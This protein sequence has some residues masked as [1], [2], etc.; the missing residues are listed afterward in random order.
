[1]IDTRL[2]RR[3]AV[4][5]VFFLNGLTLSTYIVR[6]PSFKSTHALSDALFGLSGLLFALAA[7]VCM[8]AVGPLAARIGTRTILAC[9]LA[10][11]PLLLA[12]LAVA[13]GP[14]WYLAGA[15]VLGGVHG[16]T[17]AAMNASAVAVERA[18]GR[19]I[20]NGCHAAWSISAVIAS[21]ST[22]A[23]AHAGVSLTVHLITAAAVLLLAGMITARRL[24]DSGRSETSAP[25]RAGWSRPLVLLG[26]TATALMICEGA[27]L[28][29][30]GIFLHEERGASLSLAA[31]GITAYTGAQALGRLAGDRFTDR[32]RLFRVGAAIA[33]CG[34]TIGVL[35]PHPGVA[36]AGFA[37][38]GLGSS[39]LVPLT[40]SAVGRLPGASA[41]ALVS[42]LT[43]F[44]YSGILLGPALIGGVAD[45][46]G[47]APT[48][49]VVIPLML[50]ALLLFPTQRGGRP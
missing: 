48:M 37:L 49:T 13:P 27:A 18:A 8:Q 17:D 12:G 16:A 46:I 40:F 24:P 44:T 4:T 42:R 50:L 39:V 35:A 6:A 25:A 9:A 3:W 2:D 34:F 14:R 11:M 41:A 33:T 38:A 19:P 43:T 1:M 21:L 47:L 23:L 29:W 45:R 28:G 22:A 36:V 20:L 5:A 30:G 26:L 32:N 31:V 7:L 15:A 10:V